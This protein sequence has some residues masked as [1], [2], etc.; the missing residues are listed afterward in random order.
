M[1]EFGAVLKAREL[2]RKVNPQSMPVT[3]EAY[4]AEIGA[5][6]RPQT[7]LSP[8]EPGWSFKS[9]GTLYICTNASDRLERQRFTVCHEIA[10]AA[11]NLPSDHQTATLWSY[12]KKPLAEVFCDIFAAELLLPFPLFKPLAE[13]ATLGFAV[14][15]DLAA[16]FCASISATGSRL[17]AVVSTPCA[18]VL[19]E[20][21]RVR[22]ASRSASLR[23]ANAW[24]S[25]RMELP[26][27]SQSVMARTGEAHSIASIDADAWF[28]DW[29]R[30]GVL[31]EEARHSSK[32]DQTLTLLW[33]EDE[34][35][36]VAPA[37]NE[38]EEE[39]GLQELDGILR[40]KP[41]TRRR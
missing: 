39:F 29:E 26:P 38:A 10:H 17:A 19:S 33:F 41:R 37:R 5:I 13:K 7:D 21:G 6:I 18:F 14:I 32:W 2:V 31:R 24:I 23:E 25:P 36:P 16:Q 11:M 34:E 1:D 27:N 22:Y 15:D 4:A 3:V 35:V 40:F 30:G 9:D 12:V 28:N 8:D 20:Q